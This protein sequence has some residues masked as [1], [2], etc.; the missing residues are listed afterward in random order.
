VNK[1]GPLRGQTALLCAT[2]EGDAEAVAYLV[3]RRG[4]DVNAADE[5]GIT[6]L[7]VAATDGRYDICEYL[8]RHGA[9]PNGSPKEAES[10]LHGACTNA[11]PDVV[12][13]LIRC[14]A[15]INKRS[16][17]NGWTPLMCVRDVELARFLLDH[18]ADVNA[19]TPGGM[20]V[21]MVAVPRPDV[22]MLRLLVERG[23]DLT[24]TD[25]QGRT[26][27]DYAEQYGNKA[28][29]TYLREALKARGTTP[30]R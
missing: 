22:A 12:R 23:I 27:L 5:A 6:P 3:E 4:A 21:L 20:N 2:H 29:E 28:A 24:A 7:S 10:P 18:G 26:A 8:Y 15:D 19:R 17:A 1:Q 13:L 11:H 25:K 9:D 16:A 14:G 30:S